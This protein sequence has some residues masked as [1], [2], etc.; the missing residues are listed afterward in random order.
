M[1][2]ALNILALFT[3]SFFCATGYTSNVHN[4]ASAVTIEVELPP[5]EPQIIRNFLLWKI[6]GVCEVMSD[7]ALNPLSFKMKKNK[8]SLNNV[9][10]TEGDSLYITAEN[11]QKFE[12][13]AEPKASVE[14]I[15]HGEVMVKVR[16][17]NT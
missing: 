16:C 10:F 1:I 17:V 3:I 6:K 4:F 13:V 14:V 8:G 11:G 12:L 5:N 2:R 15:N 7:A 9:E